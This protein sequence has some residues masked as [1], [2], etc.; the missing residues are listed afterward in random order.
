MAG[1][2]SQWSSP[3]MI[4]QDTFKYSWCN[5]SSSSYVHMTIHHKVI[6][7]QRQKWVVVVP[8]K[9]QR[10]WPLLFSWNDIPPGLST[11]LLSS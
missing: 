2:F 6:K 10:L 5:L 3:I 9:R 4:L 7:L 11:T 1:F 8:T